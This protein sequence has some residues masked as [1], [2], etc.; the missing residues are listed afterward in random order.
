[1]NRQKE[2]RTETGNKIKAKIFYHSKYKGG[3]KTY[4]R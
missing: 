1:M 4:V 3:K 2:A